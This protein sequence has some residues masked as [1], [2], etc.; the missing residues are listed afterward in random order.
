MSPTE[1]VQRQLEAYNAHDLKGFAA[2][3]TEDIQMFRLP[4]RE[5]SIRN[6]TEMVEFYGDNRFLVPALHAEILSRV[7]LGSKVIDHERIHG[8][9][10][11]PFECVV[12]Y[13]VRDGL[14]SRTWSVWP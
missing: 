7:V 6:K 12:I 5:P 3:Y 4:A 9:P 11:S 14:I 8:L 2:C 13:E 10:D 1:V